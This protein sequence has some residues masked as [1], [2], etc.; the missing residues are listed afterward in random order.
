MLQT[1]A[2]PGTCSGRSIRKI[3]EGLLTSFKTGF[4]HL[5]HADLVGR[6]EAIFD[7][8]QD[9]K[10][11]A[12]LA[13]E[14]EHG[15]D[16]VLEQSRPG[17]GAVLGDVADQESRQAGF[18][19]QHDD[20]ARASRTWAMLPGADGIAEE[21]IV[22]TESITEQAGLDFLDVI[23]NSLQRGFAED[24]QIGRVRCRAVR[25]AS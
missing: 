17:D 19:R 9:A 23:E 5:E 12:A 21:K 6:A 11:M 22:C 4:L 2:E 25:R 20:R 3:S 7:R 13:L 10:A 14:V 24:E 18:F 15:V 16:H 8:A 1:T